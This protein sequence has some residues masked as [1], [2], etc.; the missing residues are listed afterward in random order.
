MS[1]TISVHNM[2][3]PGLS[4]EFSC[5]ELV[6]SVPGNSTTSKTLSVLAQPDPSNNLC[7]SYYAHIRPQ[8]SPQ[9]FQ[10]KA[11]NTIGGGVSLHFYP[12]PPIV[13]RFLVGLKFE[14][15]NSI[16]RGTPHYILS[17]AK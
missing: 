16:Y 6:I 4:L 11:Q 12:W 7:L 9:Q 13:I 1:E 10:Q 3:S 17:G 15:F 14:G 2:F 5:I 8:L